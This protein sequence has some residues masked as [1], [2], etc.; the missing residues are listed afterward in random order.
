METADG[1]RRQGVI[2]E[3]PGQNGSQA[4]RMALGESSYGSTLISRG[5]LTGAEA[6]RTLG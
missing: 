3:M 2:R 5:T 4:R 6:F 1:G